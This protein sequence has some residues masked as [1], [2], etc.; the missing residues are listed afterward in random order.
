MI[1]MKKSKQNN[2][3]RCQIILCT[4]LCIIFIA[5]PI[6]HYCFCLHSND[7]TQ[8]MVWYNFVSPFIAIANV[9]AFVG[10]TIAIFLGESERQKAHEQ[11]NIQNTIITKLQQIEKDLT[12]AESALRSGSVKVMHFYTI[13][14]LLYRYENY[15]KQMPSLALLKKRKEEKENAAKIVQQVVEGRDM[16]INEYKRYVEQSRKVVVS[17]DCK[18]LA[19]KLNLIIA[20]LE[21]FEMTIIQDISLTVLEEPK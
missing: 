1:T 11:V 6:L 10:L 17:N 4:L 20:Y 15:F 8:W 12:L 14:L 21:E 2:E 5:G 19:R 16:F 13:Y 18:L 9:I 3:A 7:S